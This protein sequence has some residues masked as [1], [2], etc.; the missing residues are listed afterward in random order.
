MEHL[1]TNLA[2][3]KQLVE[4]PQDAVVFDVLGR[5]ETPKFTVPGEKN[6]SVKLCQSDGKG[7]G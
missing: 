5:S 6:P 1:C 4:Y 2:V 3:L 7:V